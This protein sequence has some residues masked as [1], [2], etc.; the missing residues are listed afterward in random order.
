MTARDVYLKPHVHVTK[1]DTQTLWTLNTMILDFNLW[2]NVA[3]TQ[4]FAYQN[5]F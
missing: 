2:V 4:I 1:N 5:E 3:N